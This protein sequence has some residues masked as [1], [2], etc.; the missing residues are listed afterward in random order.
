MDKKRGVLM[1]PVSLKF[2]FLDGIGIVS[3]IDRNM[4]GFVQRSIIESKISWVFHF[5]SAVIAFV[6]LSL[7]RGL[8]CK[9]LTA[10]NAISFCLNHS[11]SPLYECLLR[12]F[13]SLSASIASL[14]EILFPVDALVLIVQYLI[15]ISLSFLSSIIISLYNYS[16]IHR[17]ILSYKYHIKISNKSESLTFQPVIGGY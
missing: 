16:M 7:W 13:L 9:F 8:V 2:D 4:S 12:I 6:Y 10:V 3:L 1:H 15:Y 14:R 11:L 17:I 5:F